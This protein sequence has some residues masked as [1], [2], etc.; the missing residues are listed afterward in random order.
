[1][2][3]LQRNAATSIVM[4]P[5]V[6]DSNGTSAMTGLAATLAV[7]RINETDRVARD[8][9]DDITHLGGGYYAVP[10]STTDTNNTS[11]DAAERNVV[12]SAAPTG[13]LPVWI[14]AFLCEAEFIQAMNGIGTLPVTLAYVASTSLED[15]PTVYNMNQLFAGA[16]DFSGGRVP[17]DV[18]AISGDST[19]ADNA[20]K[21]FDGTGYTF[22]NSTFQADIAAVDGDAAAAT[23][24]KHTANAPL[25]AT[26]AAGTITTTAFPVTFTGTL[27][28]DVLN[29]RILY[30]MT[31]GRAK[32]SQLISDF[33]GGVESGTITLAAV[34]PA[35]LEAGD[36]VLI[37]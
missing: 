35:A 4:G 33:A 7:Y 15:D 17:A 5:F 11:G 23:L 3:F 22:P 36:T 26:V 24:L 34:L 27:S 30:V 14:H 6:S 19:A 8:S 2:I 31:G 29:G 20:E 12:Y 25:F 16:G 9:T 18:T 32:A 10:L 21:A 28:N 37:V 1:M 13:A